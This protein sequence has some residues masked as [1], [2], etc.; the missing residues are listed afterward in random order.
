MSRTGARSVSQ[1]VGNRGR[2]R[3][4][5]RTDAFTTYVMDRLLHR[6]GRSRH[7][8]ELYLKG[9]LLVANLVDSPHRFTRDI[10]VLKR[11]GRPSADDLRRVFREI[12]CVAADD[13]IVFPKDGV[14][15]L[16]ASRD[17]DG[18]DGVKVFVR[19]SVGQREVGLRVDVGFGDAVVP[20]ASRRSLAPFLDG[21]EPATVLAYDGP[22][23]AA[24]LRATLDRRR[25]P[26]DVR[27][28][29]DV[30][31]VAGDRGWQAAWA[32]MLREKAVARPVDLRAAVARFDA[33][34]R[35]VLEA[36]A[37]ELEPPE[38]WEAG[39]PWA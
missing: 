34:V 20:P 18:Y 27:V 5:D 13:G 26:P 12:V 4:L 23:L 36:L 37:A 1:R 19:A 11:R 22:N 38:R 30:H 6:L 28:L 31:E 25:T 32:T 2:E 16:V 7:A 3:S 15:A 9:G 10:D 17:E 33:F 35:P 14:R 29:D 24:S 21:D 39:G 8:K